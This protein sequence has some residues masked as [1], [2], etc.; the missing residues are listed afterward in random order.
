M[1]TILKRLQ[2]HLQKI[3]RINSFVFVGRHQVSR[4][5]TNKQLPVLTQK[6]KN[7]QNVRPI[8]TSVEKQSASR[9][10]PGTYWNL[11]EWRQ[12][13]EK[14]RQFCHGYGPIMD[15][16]NIHT[17]PEQAP[18]GIARKVTP[19]E[20][21]IKQTSWWKCFPAVFR[22]SRSTVVA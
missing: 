14:Y 6:A 15:A 2:K 19:V 13:D 9:G 8:S 7:K 16:E 1:N 11:T 21:E 20:T 10:S 5:A 22:P 4:A 3:S 17:Y 18:H 12:R